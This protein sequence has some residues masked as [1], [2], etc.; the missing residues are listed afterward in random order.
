MERSPAS[1]SSSMAI[2]SAWAK[3]ENSAIA[4]PSGALLAA[5]WG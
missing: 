5:K 1:G 3:V 2:I 4:V